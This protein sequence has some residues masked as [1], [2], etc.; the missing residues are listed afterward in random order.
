MKALKYPRK[1]LKKPRNL[2][3]ARP[4]YKTSRRFLADTHALLWHFTNDP[5]ISQ[6]AKEIFD[7]TETGEHII[8]IPSIVIAECL[9][10]FDK[11]KI[12]FDFKALF[13]QIRRSENYAIIPLDHKVLLKMVEI[14]DVPELHDKIIVA[15][16][17]LLKVPLITKD[18]F[19]RNLKTITTIW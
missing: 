2:F 1:I 13:N 19:L 16:A 14:T 18:S 10:I 8:F 11:K 5:K 6:N 7:K 4:E 17:K 9:S 3:T 12:T 15:T